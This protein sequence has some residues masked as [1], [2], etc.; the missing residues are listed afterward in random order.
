MRNITHYSPKLWEI[1]NRGT[2]IKKTSA[3]YKW[4]NSDQGEVVGEDGVYWIEF[5]S[6]YHDTMTEKARKQL[7]EIMRAVF[8]CEYIYNKYPIE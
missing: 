8:D 2:I 4:L 5:F 7:D 3:L 6:Q 1:V